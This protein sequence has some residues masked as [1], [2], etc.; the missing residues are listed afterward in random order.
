MSVQLPGGK[1]TSAKDVGFSAP[2]SPFKDMSGGNSDKAWIS[3]RTGNTISYLSECGSS[4]EPTLQ[5][6]ETD[7][8]GALS[9]LHILKSDEVSFNGRAAR[10]SISQGKIDGVPVQV[11]LVVFKK[12]GCSYTLSYGGV[13]K[14]FS[15]EQKY[16][17]NFKQNF[18]A[19]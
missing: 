7:S 6:L 14:Q 4:S 15:S 17:E 10:E 2:G 18:K 5:Q 11:A 16:F 19:P 13:E 9:D 12:N 1:V 8:L 3:E